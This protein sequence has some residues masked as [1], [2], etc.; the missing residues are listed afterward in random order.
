LRA[1]IDGALPLGQTAVI[2]QAAA[3]GGGVVHT[4]WNAA[5][6]RKIGG[7]GRHGSSA[8]S[9]HAELDA[10][11]SLNGRLQALESDVFNA[12]VALNPHH[13]TELIVLVKAD[14]AVLRAGHGSH[15]RLVGG[16]V[17]I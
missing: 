6:Y 14:I 5:L 13:L 15:E 12:H 9:S 17:Q 7:A 8:E 11:V 10:Y 4:Q 3:N 1:I 16:V 2:E